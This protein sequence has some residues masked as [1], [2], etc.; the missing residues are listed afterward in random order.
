MEEEPDSESKQEAERKSPSIKPNITLRHNVHPHWKHLHFAHSQQIR[1][2]IAIRAYETEFDIACYGPESITQA[3]IVP[4]KQDTAVYLHLPRKAVI[5]RVQEPGEETKSLVI[6]FGE[7]AI[8][9]RKFREIC[10]E[11]RTL[12]SFAIENWY[13]HLM[14]MWEGAPQGTVTIQNVFDQTQHEFR[15]QN[16]I[17]LEA[18]RMGYVV[19]K[20]KWDFR[21]KSGLSITEVQDIFLKRTEIAVVTSSKTDS[22][23]DLELRVHRKWTADIGFPG[24][25]LK[26]LQ[27]PVASA[28]FHGPDLLRAH[29]EVASRYNNA[30][31]AYAR[32]YSNTALVVLDV[33]Y[34]DAGAS[35]VMLTAKHGRCSAR[36]VRTPGTARSGLIALDKPVRNMLGREW[37]GRIGTAASQSNKSYEDVLQNLVEDFMLS[38][39]IYS[40]EGDMLLLFRLGI[41]SRIYVDGN[42]ITVTGLTLSQE[43]VTAVVKEWLEPIIT[44]A[45]GQLTALDE[46]VPGHQL[47][48]VRR[49]VLMTG[50]WTVLPCIARVCRAAL[51]DRFGYGVIVMMDSI[52]HDSAMAAVTGALVS[53]TTDH[54]GG[55]RLSD[56]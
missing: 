25:R 28:L 8:D 1:L 4:W 31:Q 47:H 23:R 44:L 46:V 17:G 12:E 27:R 43:S 49:Q 38:L 53:M 41:T 21:K 50:Y 9:A 15:I 26:L 16:N 6:F 42:L 48:L 14:E 39:N 3:A 18:L 32:L 45:N 51:C 34:Q 5:L 24:S 54:N 30:A 55:W 20:V 13:Q 36:L 10:E 52:A 35:T 22:F 56:D 29:L 40:S 37:C 7:D 2:K 19:E 33:A 11:M